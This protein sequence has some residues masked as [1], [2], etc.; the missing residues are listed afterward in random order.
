MTQAVE[1]QDEKEGNPAPG[2]ALQLSQV[3]QRLDG[4]FPAPKELAN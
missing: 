2:L 1:H 4:V 3:Q